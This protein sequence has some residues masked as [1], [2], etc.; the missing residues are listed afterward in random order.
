MG[1][2][3]ANGVGDSIDAPTREQMRHMLD[4]LDPT[5]EEH[6]AAWLARDDEYSIEWNVDGRLVLEAPGADRSQHLPGGASRAQALDLWCA[7]AQ[8]DLAHVLAQPWQPG[9]GFVMTPERRAEMDR[10]QRQMDRDFYVAL[11]PERADTPCRR[12]GC[13]RGAIEHSMFCR[14]HHF[15]S[16]RRPDCPFDD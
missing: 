15:E 13:A 3:I 6:G 10:V 4:S 8:G 7:L 1:F 2:R 12:Q 9:N 5:D 14:V 11:G 16:S